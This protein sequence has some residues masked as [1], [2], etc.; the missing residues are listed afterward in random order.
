M[1]KD[2]IYNT[3]MDLVNSWEWPKDTPNMPMKKRTNSLGS[4]CRVLCW[5][6][7]KEGSEANTLLSMQT[8]K[9]HI[10]ISSLQGPHHIAKAAVILLFVSNSCPATP[11]PH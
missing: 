1:S 9:S 8:A 2:T 11:S 7:Q 10:H 6:E 4:C 5:M 3:H